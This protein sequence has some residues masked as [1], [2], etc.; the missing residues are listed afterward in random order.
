MNKS[1]R[2]LVAE[3]ERLEPTVARAY[4]AEVQRLVGAASIAEVE[5]LISVGNIAGVITALQ[6]SEADLSQ[7]LESIRGVYVTG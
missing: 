5:S 4:L 7:L 2:Q 3:L 1:A 6:F